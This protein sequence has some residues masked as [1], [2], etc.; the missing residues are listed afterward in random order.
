M[1]EVRQIARLWC[2]VHLILSLTWFLLSGVKYSTFTQRP[3]LEA[4]LPEPIPFL[5]IGLVVLSNRLPSWQ[6]YTHVLMYSGSLVLV[7]FIMWKGHFHVEQETL[8]AKSKSLKA[9]FDAIHDNAEALNRLNRFV[10][11]EES[12]KAFFFSGVQLLMQFNVLQFLGLDLGTSLV[13]ISLP[14]TMVVTAYASPVVADGA[15]EVYVVCSLVALTALWSSLQASRLQRQRFA[16]D[17]ALQLSL[18]REAVTSQRLADQER[19]AR[20]A[21]IKADNILNHILKNLMADASGCIYLFAENEK[22]TIPPDLQQA[23]T[24][25]DRGMR[26][27]RR[28]QALV[29]ITA[30]TYC[31]SREPVPLRAFG[32]EL[33]NGRPLACQFVDEVVLLDPLLCDILLDNAI[34]N[35]LRHGDTSQE[36]VAFS[37]ALHPLDEHA[38]ELTFAVTNRTKGHKPP[39]TPEFVESVLQGAT[40]S[41]QG[42]GLSDHLGLQHLF[43]AAEV[44]GIRLSLQQEGDVVLLQ[45]TLTVQRECKADVGGEAPSPCA[46]VTLE[47]LRI[48]CLDDSLVA[49]RLLEHILRL[50]LPSCTVEVFG[51]DAQ[52]IRSFMCASLDHADMVIVDNHLIYKDAQFLGTQ[53]LSELFQ[54]GYCGFACMRSANAAP[55]DQVQYFASGAHCCLGKDIGPREM[56]SR[57][58]ASYLEFCHTIQASYSNPSW[59]SEPTFAASSSRAD[60]EKRL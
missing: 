48:V 54:N 5:A 37:M 34:N 49:R 18:E 9:V 15:I 22:R 42:N 57:L 55:E 2:V 20:E 56:V 40:G 41:E 6:R 35:A 3:S 43:M 47:G 8:V 58:Q 31:T 45:A 1:A 46:K 4:F 50:H 38:A 14:I 44:H 10:N 29:R 60:P 30:G 33:A 12:R 32:E 13:C 11:L 19:E 26:W 24:C 52:E 25:L 21:S 53:L 51:S 7:G 59:T 28:R 36:P 39:M 17:H 16:T 23:L 27:C